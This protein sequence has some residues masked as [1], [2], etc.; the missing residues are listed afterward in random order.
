MASE[1][2]RGKA[3]NAA[4]I[5]RAIRIPIA[6]AKGADEFIERFGII[7][8]P[9]SQFY[10]MADEVAGIDRRVAERVKVEIDDVNLTAIDHD[11]FRMEVSMD[12]RQ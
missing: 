6:R 1:R 12:R 10:Q 4:P 8:V 7:V 9:D 3:L 11:I 2:Q 5:G